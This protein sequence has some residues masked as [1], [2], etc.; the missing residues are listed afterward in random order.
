[1]STVIKVG[2]TGPILQRLSTVDLADHLAE[3]EAFIAEAQRRASQIAVIADRDAERLRTTARQMGYREGFDKGYKEGTDRGR[4]AA[5]DAATRKFDAQHSDIVV[6]MESAIA[7]IDSLKGDLVI[8]AEQHLLAFAVR[9]AQALTYA[10][11]RLDRESAKANLDRSLRLVDSKTN[12]VVHAHPDD[13]STL[14]TFAASVLEK[15]EKSRSLKI[16]PDEKMA[17]GGCRVE[18]G[19]FEVDATLDTQVEEMVTLLLGSRQGE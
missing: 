17:P 15:A 8:Q 9:L 19:R 1:M 4:E 10:I 5:W 18:Y 13:V 14:G 12:L 3:A 11:G 16:V 6:V 7:E 2:Q